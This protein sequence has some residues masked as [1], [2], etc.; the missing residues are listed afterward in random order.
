MISSDEKPK[1]VQNYPVFLKVPAKKILVLN[2]SILK[3][4]VCYMNLSS[5]IVESSSIWVSVYGKNS[6]CQKLSPVYCFQFQPVVS[7]GV[8]VS[9]HH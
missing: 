3:L 9:K 8:V 4:K 2:F 6:T 5:L 1:P 7:I